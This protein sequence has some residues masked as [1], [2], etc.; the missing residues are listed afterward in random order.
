MIRAETY[1]KDWIIAV[2]KKNKNADPILVEK[3]IR[4]FTLLVHLQTQ[5]LD[6]IFK[7]GTSLM[8]LFSEPKRLSI[9]IDII[10]PNKK[11]DIET[12]CK[13]I[14]EASNFTLMNYKKGM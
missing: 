4:A 5:N 9:D 2:C 11:T 14:V 13:A 7:G 1:T 12:V 6:F 10:V 8:L 3:V